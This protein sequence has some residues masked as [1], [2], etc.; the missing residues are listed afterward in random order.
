MIKLKLSSKMSECPDA[1]RHFFDA[2]CL[3]GPRCDANGVSIDYI[4]QK[5]EPW[6]GYYTEDSKPAIVF[7]T[8]NDRSYFLLRWS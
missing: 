2:E 5:L 1:W 6:C 8:E 7:E 4:N 3:Y